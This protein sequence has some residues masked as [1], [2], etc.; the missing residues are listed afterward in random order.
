MSS[1][2][3]RSM[4]SGSTSCMCRPPIPA[5]CPCPVAWVAR[6]DSRVPRRPSTPTDPPDPA[7]AFSLVIPSLPGYGFSGPTAAPGLD[8]APDRGCL[9]DP[10]GAARLRPLR[11]SGRRL[12]IDGLVQHGGPPTRKG[13][14]PARQ[15]SDRPTA[16]GRA[17]RGHEPAERFTATGS[18]YQ[19]IQG[20]KPQTIGYLLDDSP[21]GLAGWIVEKFRDWSDCGGDPERSFT[22]GPAPDQHDALLGRP[23]PAPRRPAS[24]GR[25][26]RPAGPPFLRRS[27][28]SRPA[29]PTS[30]RDGRTE[31]AG[32]SVDTTSF[33][34]PP[35]EAVISRRWRCPI[36]SSTT[37]APSSGW[38]A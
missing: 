1:S 14:R 13:G 20:T 19:Q 23:G 35:G 8:A 11:R 6:I 26:A 4:A 12:G 17:P 30:S 15:F 36:S 5:R 33:T 2:S 37:C 3:P 9:R 28:R 22:K 34:G 7:D 10:D 25:C 18:G 31:R 24:T 21:A 38:S 32:R 16:D 27:L 29:W